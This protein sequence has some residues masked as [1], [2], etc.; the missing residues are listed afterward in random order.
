LPTLPE[1]VLAWTSQDEGQQ[2][3]FK[4]EHATEEEIAET[5]AA[6]ANSVGG[7][8]LIGVGEAGALVGVDDVKG[9]T[10]RVYVAA[11]TTAPRLDELIS[12]EEVVVEGHTI[13]VVTVP[14]DCTDTYMAGGGYRIRQGAQNVLMTAQ[15]VAEHVRLRGV[16]PFDRLPV[17]GAT[18]ASLSEEQL[19]NFLRHRPGVNPTVRPDIDSLPARASLRNL[20]IIGE[21]EGRLRPTVAGLLMFGRDP[22]EYIPQAILQ[23]AR[24]SG[25]GVSR[26]L[27][28]TEVAATIEQQIDQAMTFVER[29]IRHGTY[30][31][32]VHHVDVD[33][34]PLTAI[35]E[36]LINALCHRDYYAT[37]TAVNLN[38]FTDRIEILN[39]GGLLP[40]LRPDALEGQHRLRNQALGQLMYE[41]GLIE[42]WG[43]GI[44]RMR[45]SMEEAGLQQPAIAA[46]RDWFRITFY[47]PGEA[48]LGERSAAIPLALGLTA[49][50]LSVLNLRQRQLLGELTT[51]GSITRQQYEE[52]F[53]VERSQAHRDLQSMVELGLLHKV[54]RNRATC[55]VLATSAP[56]EI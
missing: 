8:L 10:S 26:F 6:L 54:G 16:L 22:Q 30:I 56:P 37:G 52:E 34:Y 53:K 38:I 32:R 31:E 7:V 14:D 39:P 33:E 19:V 3:G 55:Y 46:D 47:G 27:D 42:R 20:H 48:F 5:L 29:N 51:R 23:C 50:A 43:S 40:G 44:R 9:V 4:L 13:I 49:E 41:T 11:H 28:R 36:G 2:I 35:R 17:A 21:Q 15:A 1:Q 18:F 45:L 24:F 25:I 12:V